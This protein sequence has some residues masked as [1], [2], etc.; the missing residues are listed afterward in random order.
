MHV[1]IITCCLFL[2]L[3][4]AAAARQSFTGKLINEEGNAIVDGNILLLRSGE[5]T[6]SDQDGHFFLV[7]AKK[8]DTLTVSAAGY[9]TLH[10]VLDSVPATLVLRR[11]FGEL[12]EVT[13]QTGYE[14]LPRERAT[15]SF[16][17]INEALLNEQVSTGLLSR[18]PFV[19]NGLSANTAATT[20]PG[21]VSPSNGLV[22]RGIS[23]LSSAISNPL[24]ILDNFPYEG[25]LM[26][27][28][29][30]DVES[31]TL[32]KDAAAASIWGARAGNGVIVISTKK[33]RFEQ[34]LR[35]Q[36]S[37]NTSLT[38]PTDLMSL[39]QT[40]TAD[41][42]A[43][44]EFL[45]DKGFQLADTLS[46][47][48][49]PFSE[50][51]QL[52]LQERRGSIT[53][54][55]KEERLAQLRTQDVRKEY[56]KHF[57]KTAVN[58]QY[59]LNLSGGS[60]RHAWLLSVGYDRNSSETS[61]TYQRSTWRWNNTYKL[62][63]R[64]QVSAA[65]DYTHTR[66]NNGR[67]GYG[68]IG[69]A[70]QALP[71][72]T[73]FADDNGNPLPL[74]NHY[75]KDY[76]DTVGNGLLLDWRYVPL[77]D[78]QHTRHS[79]QLKSI[80]AVLG[81]AYNFSRIFSLDVKYRYQEQT[82][83]SQTTQSADAYYTRD[84]INSFSQINRAT[85]K[86]TYIV[87][88]GAIRDMA[89][90]SLLAQDLRAQMRMVVARNKSSFNMIAGAQVGETVS[91]ASGYRIY[92]LSTEYYTFGNV[93]YVN[94]YPNLVTGSLDA[95]ASNISLSR[96]NNRMLSIYSNASY[97]YDN[98]YSFSLSARRDASN[99]FGVSTNNRWKPMWSAGLSWNIA[100]ERFY[101]VP[102]L[103]ELKLRMTYG[104]QGN[105]DPSRVAV[106]TFRYVGSPNPYTQAPYS[107]LENVY[108]PSLR[109]ENVAMLNMGIDFAWKNN[110][111]RGSV[112]HYRKYIDDLYD[113]MPVD[114]TTGLRRSFMV[115]NVAAM[116]G[117]GWDI[118]L[119]TLNIDRAIKWSTH[120]IV[121]SNR[122][123][124]THRKM[125]LKAPSVVSGAGIPG[126]SVY[127]YFAYRWAGLDPQTG[128]PRGYVNKEV[129]NDYS[130]IMNANYPLEDLVYIGSLSPRWF[131]SIGNTLQWKG[132]SLSLRVSFKLDYYIRRPSISYNT[133]ISTRSGHSDYTLRWQ[134]PGDE[135]HTNVPSFI[136]PAINNRDNFYLNSEVLATRGD[137]IRLQYLNFSYSLP[138][139]AGKAVRDCQFFININNLGLI[140]KAN[141]LGLDPDHYQ[142]TRPRKTLATGVRLQL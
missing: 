75:A 5:G 11:N 108:N 113:N 71:P 104:T 138:L 135:A 42:I 110:R 130:A 76:L 96:T 21:R 51:Y 19:A 38:P 65:I 24:I 3:S 129:S 127:A 47:Q 44:E 46:I 43:L 12:E 83:Q 140:W 77:T 57:Y 74:Y 85:G 56:L 36:F 68:S 2:L 8:G 63:K 91:K 80:N 32:L 70:R 7:A 124:I 123:K 60:Q 88:L 114:P 90:R 64:L 59:A 48:R 105:S 34:P 125:E 87:P 84:Y 37:A 79:N 103:N 4:G 29:P 40:G 128:D 41:I 117:Q 94:R 141:R 111:I 20:A 33:S 142:S 131:G 86:V 89:G 35:I 45:F 102:W 27:I 25:D 95:I 18:L 58:Q 66:S 136:Y 139:K 101:S 93:D 16:S 99:L 126:Y 39:P 98:R 6:S 15:G 23:T 69:F 53:A 49:Y 67:P 107:E 100:R 73:R 134:Q 10:W 133:L 132:F 54:Q 22:L 55:Q 97:T 1:K 62:T 14:S 115:Q 81:L 122:D 13:L 92:G 112:E 30:N 50:V 119:N 26:N 9:F 28:N 109:W 72:Y 106:T 61:E 121:N 120:L 78:Y 31:V 52:L 137:H 118:E 116:Q 17:R 82:V